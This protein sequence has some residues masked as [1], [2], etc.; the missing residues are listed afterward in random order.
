MVV[1]SIP[2]GVIQVFIS[3]REL[4][5]SMPGSNLDSVSQ[6]SFLLVLFKKFPRSLI[7]IAVLNPFKIGG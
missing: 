4:Y 7:Q 6:D 1:G 2:A 5:L 3:A